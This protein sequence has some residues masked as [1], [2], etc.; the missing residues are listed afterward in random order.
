MRTKYQD[1]IF[2]YLS[3]YKSGFLKHMRS[4]IGYPPRNPPNCTPNI[5][6]LRKG[7][8]STCTSWAASGTISTTIWIKP[9]QGPWKST[10]RFSNEGHGDRRGRLHRQ[11]LC[12]G[13]PRFRI[14]RPDLRQPQHRS[15]TDFREHLRH[16]DGRKIPRDLLRRPP[17]RR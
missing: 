5:W 13:P 4:D 10:K 15:H 2:E 7:S 17:E 12:I 8:T 6:R 1:V 14:R 3:E 9:W 11:P 16:I